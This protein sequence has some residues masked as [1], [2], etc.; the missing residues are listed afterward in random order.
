MNMRTPQSL[1]NEDDPNIVNM[2]SQDVDFSE[3]MWMEEMDEFDR[4]VQEELQEQ[5]MIEECFEDLYEMERLASEILSS[6]PVENDFITFDSAH[7][8]MRTNGMAHGWQDHS[9]SSTPSTEVTIV[10][11]KLNPLA[12][13][14]YPRGQC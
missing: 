9:L 5:E 1:L 12:P 8:G 14:F 3:Y 6:S 10:S 11:S 2:P 7:A 4:Q 13:E